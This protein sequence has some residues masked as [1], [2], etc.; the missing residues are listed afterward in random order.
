MLMS[1]IVH[2][3]S[4]IQGGPLA[5][6]V[7]LRQKAILPA[8]RPPYILIPTT[9]THVRERVWSAQLAERQG[10]VPAVEGDLL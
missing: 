3:N 2:C 7:D 4:L 1:G 9:G 6:D 8:A 10:C 5:L